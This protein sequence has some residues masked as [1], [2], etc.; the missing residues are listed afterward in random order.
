[1]AGP[2][3]VL[4]YDLSPGLIGY[5]GGTGETRPTASAFRLPEFGDDLGAMGVYFS[6]VVEKHILDF[7]PGLIGYESPLL[8]KHDTL[9]KLRRTYGLGVLLETIATRHDIPTFEKDPKT[10]KGHLTGNAYA[11]KGDMVEAALLCGIH[12]PPTIKEGQQ[13]AADGFAGWGLGLHEINPREAAIWDQIIRTNA[14][15][16]LL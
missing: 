10:L 4:F 8:V 3:S 11:S 13:D 9:L 12:L 1:M 16:G 7:R 14:R 2:A 15:G 5:C 6:D